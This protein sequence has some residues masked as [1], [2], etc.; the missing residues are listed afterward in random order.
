MVNALACSLPICCPYGAGCCVVG[1][2]FTDIMSIRDND[3]LCCFFSN[4]YAVP[5][6]QVVELFV[7]FYRY[8]VPTGQ[9]SIFL[10]LAVLEGQDIGKAL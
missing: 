7:L 1:F 4:Q 8:P 9:D 5:T 6:G 2:S 3:H 10:F